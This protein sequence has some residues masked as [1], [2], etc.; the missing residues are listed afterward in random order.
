MT[1]TS[2]ILLE[3]NCW[4]FTSSFV[5]FYARLSYSLLQQR[6]QY[7]Q[8]WWPYRLTSCLSIHLLFLRK[9]NV[10]STRSVRDRIREPMINCD[11]LIYCFIGLFPVRGREGCSLNCRYR[12]VESFHFSFFRDTGAD[13]FQNLI[14]F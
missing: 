3:I 8:R 4:H 12:N 11:L 9:I 13:K 2:R 6:S 14:S 1:I 5:H 10:C 7:Q